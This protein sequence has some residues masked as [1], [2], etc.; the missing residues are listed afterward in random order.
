MRWK[1][2]RGGAIVASLAFLGRTMLPRASVSA[3]TNYVD[4]D[5]SGLGDGVVCPFDLALLLGNWG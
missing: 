4:A 3:D 2:K 5:A 1:R